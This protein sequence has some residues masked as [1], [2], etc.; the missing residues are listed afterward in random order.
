[1]SYIQLRF[2]YS[3]FSDLHED[4]GTEIVKQFMYDNDLHHKFLMCIEKYDKYGKETAPHIHANIYHQD[5]YKKNTLQ[6]KFRE[7][8]KTYD[9]NLSGNKDYSIRV[10]AQ[11]DDEER[12]WRYILKESGA[13]LFC[14]KNMEDFADE[15]KKLAQDERKRTIE[16]NNKYLQKYLDKSSFKGKM[17]QFLQKSQVTTHKDFIISAIKYYLEKQ[18]TPAFTKL[19]DMF[20]EYQLL[21]GIMSVE[22]WYS[23]KY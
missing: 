14:S 2:T 6:K 12:W 3:N 4:V 8:V 17:Y 23:Q 18:T 16:L 1:M 9:Y 11:P 19:D 20:I 13:R 22:D 7:L 21:T 5:D 10:L 15:Y